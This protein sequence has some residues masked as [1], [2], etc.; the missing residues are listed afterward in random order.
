MG[1]KYSTLDLWV[2]FDTI[3]EMAKVVELRSAYSKEAVN[4]LVLNLYKNYSC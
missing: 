1:T 2:S 4:G 3:N